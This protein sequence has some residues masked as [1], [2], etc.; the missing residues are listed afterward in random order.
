MKQIAVLLIAI[1]A[2]V[3]IMA[4]EP[5][6]AYPKTSLTNAIKEYGQAMK[7]PSRDGQKL[8]GSILQITGATAAID[9]DSVPSVLPRV[10]R[11]I[12]A[13][14]D[15]ADKALMM[16]V[17]A[18]LINSIYSANSWKY[19]R[20]ETPDEPLPADI[21]EW[22]GRQFCTQ[23]HAELA[24]AFNLALN[25]PKADLTEYASIIKADRLSL[26]FFPTV[27]SFIA[28]RAYNL[29]AMDGRKQFLLPIVETMMS[30]SRPD[31][32]AEFYWFDKKL[33]LTSENVIQERG[34]YYLKN[35]DK[36]AAG[37]LLANCLDAYYKNNAP[38][39]AIPALKSFI[40]RFPNYWDIN[41]L[42]NILGRLTLAEVGV[43]SKSIIA[44]GVKFDITVNYSYT[45][46]AGYKI[47]QINAKTFEKS[48]FN[49]SSA[50]EIQSVSF[51]TDPQTASADTI[52]SATIGKSGYYVIVPVVNGKFSKYY[53]QYIRC[54][55]FIPTLVE[56]TADNLI[57][58]VDYE[59]GAP[60][61]G[62][63]ITR[64]VETIKQT[65]GT[66]DKNG[67]VSFI[68][69]TPESLLGKFTWMKTSFDITCNNQT[70]NFFNNHIR[71]LPSESY[72]YYNA[73][74]M[75]DRMI[76]HPG[77]SVR[78]A[79][80]VYFANAEPRQQPNEN[81]HIKFYDTNSQ[82]VDS[83]TAKTNSNGRVNGCF[84]TP[85]E[86]LTGYY[87]IEV[88]TA[89]GRYL[90]NRFVEVS[91]F[92]LPTFKIKEIEVKRDIPAAG[93]VTLISEAVTYS[94]MPVAG[95]KVEAEIWEAS[96]WRWFSP[97]RVIGHLSATTDSKGEFNFIVSDSITAS[98]KTK[99]FIAKI[100]VASAD[101][102][103]RKSSVSFSLGKPYSIDFTDIDK[104]INVDQNVEYPF[105]AYNASGKEVSIDIHWWLT[106]ADGNHNKDKAVVSGNCTTDKFSSINLANVPAGKWC[107]SVA[108]VDSTLA[109]S[110][111]EAA[112]ITTYSL[113]KNLVPTDDAI[114]ITN[115][116]ISATPDGKF[117]LQF[118]VAND[119]TYVY[120]AFASRNRLISTNIN[121][122]N[123]GFHT[124]DFRLPGNREDGSVY[125][126]TVRNGVQTSKQL[127]VNI[128]HKNKVSLE[129]S[130]MRDRLTVGSK[131]NWTVK[132]V[133]ESNRP[134]TGAM[135]ATMFNSALN[136]LLPYDLPSDFI[137][138]RE[139]TYQ[140]LSAITNSQ[141]N[142]ITFSADIKGLREV[143]LSAPRFNPSINLSDLR[144]YKFK[145]LS[146]ARANG[147]V[148]AILVTEDEAY[149]ENASMIGSI[150]VTES[151]AAG[152]DPEEDTS[153]SDMD[154]ADIT[155]ENFEYRDG[156][157]L[158]AFWMPDLVFDKNG[159]ALLTFT[160]PDA[161]TTWSFNAFAWTGDLRSTK[162]VR[163]FIASKPVMV[164]PNLPR[165]L[166]V[167]D[168]ARVL[169]TVYNN[170]D[171]A[172]VVTSTVE[173]F[174][175]ASG[176][177][178]STFTSSDT[179][180]ASASAIVAASVTAPGDVAA[181]GY[182]VRSTLGRFTDGE[183]DFIPIVPSTSDVIESEN[184]YLNPGEESVSVKIPKGN[185]MQST[186]DYTA[187]PAWNI[188]K[189]LPGLAASNP[190]TSTGAAY[191][192]FSAAT[193]S[194]LI[195]TYP[196]LAKVLDEWAENPETGALTSRLSKNNELK[197]AVLNSTPWVQ[198][199]ASDTERMA[200]LSLLFDKDATSKAISSSI[201]TLKKLQRADGGWS[202]GEWGDKSSF[203]ATN[204]VLQNLGR[205]N[206]IGYMPD[207]KDLKNM[208]TRAIAYCEAEIP[209]D[210]KIEGSFT[211]ITT[212]FP[213]VKIGLRGTQI[214]NATV[215]DIIGTWKKSST[216]HKSVEALILAAKGYPAVA[217]Q[218]LTSLSEFAVDSPD[219]GTSFPSSGNINDY[220]D[221]L[222]AFARLMPESKIIDGMRQWLVV[223]QQTTESLGSVDP[224][225]LIA[226]FVS[227]GSNWLDATESKT[228]VSIGGRQL[229]IEGAEQ[230]TGHIVMTLPANAAGKKLDI[231]RGNS[232]VPSYGSVISRFNRQSTEIKAASCS[233]LS[234]EKRIT[235]LRD[236]RWQYVDEVRL[237]E[238]IRVLLTIK[239]K[240][241]LE[242]VT[243]I[244]ERPASFEPVDQLPGWVWSAGAGFYRENR[245][246]ETRLFIDYLN[247]GTYQI[248]IDMTA[249]VAGTFTTGIATV[250]SQLAPSITAHSAGSRLF[251][252]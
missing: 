250:Q 127:R 219:K 121:C 175:I 57:T 136:A 25:S 195:K 238:Q 110:V 185:D 40:D 117:S 176:E 191:R 42:K 94:G 247:K 225:R 243:V 142:F 6:F 84:I 28:S 108:P 114:F 208:I 87:R 104:P 4:A 73:K 252:E 239:A 235:A 71:T 48:N 34:K 115:D 228:A 226:A 83:L 78:W 133:D 199:A 29:P 74:I 96:W 184:F 172:A 95:A 137:I 45:K 249:S 186:L 171:S 102:E 189:E 151:K 92:K 223:R 200:R 179:I 9:T 41:T 12:D 157:V 22:N 143:F 222:Y 46:N 113:K 170:S 128:D 134:Q 39:W 76:Y 122:L 237:G 193:A 61:K 13:M 36:E 62:A 220:A 70:F 210:V 234:I 141:M 245:D 215:Q 14:P 251:C 51:I 192:L 180:A 154:T 11:A 150:D 230:A 31:S 3:N 181:I 214:V 216:W 233:D 2:S 218:I 60:I 155:T 24:N 221:L 206:A 168:E 93:D 7:N 120:Q 246:S 211:F 131:E 248:T 37:Y 188:I 26:R 16:T 198:A 182:R 27:L 201:E 69:D 174:D 119:S 204:I 21:T 236:G 156:E 100:S 183:Q 5:D 116:K 77:D 64:N 163:E 152:V 82:L 81:L 205:L 244:D 107:V 167:G 112:Y 54:M 97:D 17:K 240:R 129:C 161:N 213:D 85:T 55:S 224:T 88:T 164:Q 89:D 123:R 165:F 159:E 111:K 90:N 148:S 1:L 86:G 109:D 138:P 43:K 66:T 18:E 242:Y 33:T 125:L 147:S 207:D 227:C 44:P 187:N 101:G 103:V 173:I 203:W 166:R 232:E 91:D 67:I 38:E 56:Q 15:G 209:K 80:I 20:T 149:M 194:G 52:I 153:A 106:P 105:A 144:Q 32:D 229:T 231:V 178:R 63:S 132:F 241:D 160:V 140:R 98:S 72:S 49:T 146:R 158:Q 99:C 118:G 65:I 135:I 139:K 50:T 162:M 197:A 196:A 177:V 35:S 190:S 58:V 10:D 169:A 145:A 47:Y 30:Q 53:A 124:I 217:R 75:S 126:F 68:P 212:L 130:S 79:A 8:I 19:D 59:S 202:W 23:I